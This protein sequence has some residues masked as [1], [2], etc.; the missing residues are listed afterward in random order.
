MERAPE[1]I[2]TILPGGTNVSLVD[3]VKLIFTVEPFVEGSPGPHV[4]AGIAA[5]E[6]QGLPVQMG[7]F[8]NVAVGSDE[9][10]VRAIAALVQHSLGAGATRLAIQ[11]SKQ[12]EEPTHLH[13]ALDRLLDG[14]A[15][16]I[17]GPLDSL[18]REQRQRAVRLLDERGAFRMRRSVESVAD[19]LGVSR[20]T[21][22]NYLNLSRE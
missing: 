12:G 18:T 4:L 3:L 9:A 11:V 10:V 7:P 22:Y 1:V 8:D 17:G 21:V 15:R 14:V 13:G 20:I 19:A 2:V 6:A 5:V 16:E